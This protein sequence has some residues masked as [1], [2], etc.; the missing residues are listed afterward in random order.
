MVKTR[1][2]EV[3]IQRQNQD[4]ELDDLLDEIRGRVRELSDSRNNHQMDRKQSPRKL[5]AAKE[6]RKAKRDSLK[7][8]SALSTI[9]KNLAKV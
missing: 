7:F 1:A 9:K 4:Q 5:S 8:R 3:S 2:K 6:K